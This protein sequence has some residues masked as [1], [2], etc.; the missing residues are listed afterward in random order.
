MSELEQMHDEEQ[1]LFPGNFTTMHTMRCDNHTSFMFR[2]DPQHQVPEVERKDD[3]EQGMVVG[4]ASSTSSLL[5]SQAADGRCRSSLQPPLLLTNSLVPQIACPVDFCVA[6][7]KAL[8]CS[9][10]QEM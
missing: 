2:P 10:S 1:G 5:E 4:N 7:S 8:S 6:F 9:F 3:K